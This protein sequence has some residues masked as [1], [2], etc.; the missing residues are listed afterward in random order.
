MSI[1]A[2]ISQVTFFS[3]QETFVSASREKNYNLRRVILVSSC[4]LAGEWRYK[5]TSKTM[6][7][8]WYVNRSYMW[9]TQNAECRKGFDVK[10][11]MVKVML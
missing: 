3:A 4:I 11:P 10:K 7:K 1:G 9:K 8:V 2:R 6:S 5:S